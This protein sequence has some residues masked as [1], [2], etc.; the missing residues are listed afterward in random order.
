MKYGIGFA[1]EKTCFSEAST[2]TGLA[3]RKNAGCRVRQR[4]YGVG[5]E[6]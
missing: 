5:G 4:I 1:I 3:I 6:D 2:I